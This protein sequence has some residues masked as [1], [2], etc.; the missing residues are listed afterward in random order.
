L[1]RDVLY[2][3]A[4]KKTTK[5]ATKKLSIKRETIRLLTSTQLAGVAGGGS[6]A[7]SQPA[8]GVTTR[9]KTF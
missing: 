1:A 7:C 9:L 2:R 6:S 4:M 8:D 5:Q 3:L